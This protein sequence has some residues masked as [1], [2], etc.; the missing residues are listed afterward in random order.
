MNAHIRKRGFTAVFANA[1]GARNVLAQLQT[2]FED[3]KNTHI[4]RV[5]G[6]EAEFDK[7]NANLAALKVGGVGIGDNAELSP[8]SAQEERVAIGSFAKSGTETGI[9]AMASPRSGMSSDSD[10]DGGYTV[11]PVIS[12]QI[13]KKLFDVSPIGRLAR[14]VSITRGNAFEEPI[15]PSDIGAEWVGET[16][17]R[18]AL[19]TSKLKYL[20]V[21]LHEIYTNQPITQRL[22]DDSDF[23]LGLW[24]EG[25]ITD[26]FARSEGKAYIGG[27]GVGKPRGI[28]TY[29]TSVDKD[30]A[31]DWGTVQ[32]VK[33]GADGAFKAAAGSVSGADALLD[34]VYSLRAPYR[35]NARWLM[36]LSTAGTV[37]K[38]KD[39]EGR[40]VWA[41]AREGQPATLCGFPVELDEEMPDVANNSLSIAFGD[42]EQA[43]VIVDRPGLRLMRDPYTAKPHVLFYAYRR[44][45]GGLQNSEAIKL[46]QFAAS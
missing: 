41:D 16:E 18:P 29:P 30:G 17:S 42:F 46:L 34:L 9:K 12:T 25:K 14:R 38:L 27:D 3:F 40:F 5:D 39:S 11:T 20:S 24:L 33:T 23:N 45:G 36:N 28:L 31:R 4:S 44:V 10:P 2:E 7:I 32:V 22:L 43:Y 15:D 19:D 1:G 13:N 8:S 21:P 37:R 6:I 26:K 35:P